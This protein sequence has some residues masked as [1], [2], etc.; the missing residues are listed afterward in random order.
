MQAKKRGGNLRTRIV[1]EGGT[2]SVVMQF[3]VA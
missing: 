1:D 3:V 2:N